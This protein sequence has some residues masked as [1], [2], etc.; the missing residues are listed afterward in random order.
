MKSIRYALDEAVIN[1]R[2]SGQSAAMSIGTIAIAFLTLGLFL[3]LSTNLQ[4]VVGQ[5]SAS[6]EMSVYLRDDA[7]ESVRQQLTTELA[8]NAAVV[9]VE[10]VSKE[11]AL[12][13][14]K[15]DFPELGELAEASSGNPFPASLEVQLR[16]DAAATAAAELL[17]QELSGR[18][19]IA[20]VRYDRQWLTR[21]MSIVNGLRWAGL[22]VA[23]VLVLGAAFTVAAVVRLS[24]QARQQELD[25]MQLVGAPFAFIRGPSIAEGTLLGAAGAALALLSLWIVFVLVRRR[26]SETLAGFADVGEVHFLGAAELVLLF[27]AG[28]MIGALAGLLA[29]RVVR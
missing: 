11:Q 23:S 24:L 2:R 18:A 22:A 9:Q 19:D 15:T 21:L 10:Y 25:I 14:F 3:L 7:A 12:T 26:V 29:S 28:S 13:R 4:G 16:P 5:W 8:A 6:A 20:D 27:V 17:M 1:L